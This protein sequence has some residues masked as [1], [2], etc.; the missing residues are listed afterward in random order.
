MPLRRRRSQFAY[1]DSWVLR[2]AWPLV[3]RML[4]SAA[5]STIALRFKV[6]TLCAI[7]PQYVLLCIINNSKSFTLDTTIFLNPFGNTCLVF[8]S[9]PYP[10]LAMIIPHP[11]N[12]LRTRESIPFGRRQL[13][14][15]AIFL[16]DWWRL[17]LLCLR[18]FTFLTFFSGCTIVINVTTLD[19][20]TK[21]CSS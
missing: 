18:L 21:R 4:S 19:L 15:T 14:D 20:Q 3:K 2:R 11:L 9:V 8:L 12:F 1:S 7:S 13:S 6:D 5:R 16:S 17:K 10:M